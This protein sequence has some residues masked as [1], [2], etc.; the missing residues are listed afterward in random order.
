MLTL[1]RALEALDAVL[2][3]K[4]SAMALTWNTPLQFDSTLIPKMIA[5]FDSLDARIQGLIGRIESDPQIA[6]R[7]IG[8]CAADLHQLRHT[9]ALRMYP[10]ISH[11]LTADP[12]ARRLFWQSRLVM[13]GLARRIFRR[14][15]EL[16]RIIN[17]GTATAAAIEHVTKA[18]TEY[19]HRNEAEIYPLYSLAGKKSSARTRSIARAG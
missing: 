17:N 10:L 2:N 6:A 5:G 13:L 9:E 15:D 1:A 3:V 4:P 16:A 7:E 19:R 14:F 12:V 18:L 8:N 11:G